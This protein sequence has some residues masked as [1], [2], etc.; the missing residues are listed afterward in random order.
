MLLIEVV[1]TADWGRASFPI[2]AA[3]TKEPG[4]AVT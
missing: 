3:K 1:G 4:A 2:S